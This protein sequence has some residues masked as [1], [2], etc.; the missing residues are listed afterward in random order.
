MVQLTSL[1]LTNYFQKKNELTLFTKLNILRN[2]WKSNLLK[3]WIGVQTKGDK[4]GIFSFLRLIF[5][6]ADNTLFKWNASSTLNDHST[7]CWYVKH[8]YHSS[9]RWRKYRTQFTS[10]F[11]TSIFSN[12]NRIC[13]DTAIKKRIMQKWRKT[14]V[15]WKIYIYTR[16]R[17]WISQ[18]SIL[19]TKSLQKTHLFG[20]HPRKSG[21]KIMLFY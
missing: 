1:N 8:Y 16:W 15:N 9:D 4:W 17:T 12:Q 6:V 21:I 13:V 3:N 10:C 14:C 11:T 2:E 19:L 20:I 5:T 18:E 7:K